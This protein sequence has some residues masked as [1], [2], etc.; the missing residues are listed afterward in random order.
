MTFTHSIRFKFILF[1]LAILAVLLLLLNTYPIT[2]SR[3]TVFQEKQSSLSSQITV[4]SS[5]LGSL[6]RLSQNG[7]NDVLRFLDLSGF[8]R[9]VVVD[10]HGDVVF[11]DGQ[12]APDAPDLH[13]LQTALTGK[14][15][16]RSVFADAAF[17]SSI[18]VPVGSRGAMI[19]AVSLSEVD[20]ERAAIILSIQNRIVFLSLFIGLAALLLAAAFSWI[21]LRRFYSLARSMHTVAGGNYAYRHEITG[22]DEISDLEREFNTLTECLEENEKQRRRFVSD[23]SHELKTPLA[24]IRLMSDSILNTR[25]MD[26]DTM[27]EFVS[28]IRTAS[29]RLQRT[30][31][32]L[33]DLSRLDDGIHL[34]P[35]PVD[36][37]QITLD[38]LPGLRAL[39]A[40]RGVAVNARLD[41]GCVIMANADDISRVVFNLAENAIKYNVPGG[42]VEI[43]LSQDEQT[44]RLTVSDT[45]IG[46]PEEDRL[47]IFTRFY[48]VDKARSRLSGGSGLGLSIVHDA[49]LQCGG[50]I[51][52]GSNKPQGS[53]F[54]VS[55]PRPTSEETGI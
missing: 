30:T 24:S 43:L 34:I 41:D 9:I 38:V 1:V 25:Q 11:D 3:D 46:I 8:N 6:D 39:A 36:L 20:T 2:S 47:N 35:E 17:S 32:K 44:V 55:F 51:D 18:A 19:G 16:F 28:D 7:V 50:S 14:S 29:D 33:L 13:D 31:E 27:R 12:D 15:V 53:V 37:K 5:A 23:A 52:V 10:E 49:V 48:R 45:G 22:N 42:S 21:V 4:V 54:V 40:D 26:P